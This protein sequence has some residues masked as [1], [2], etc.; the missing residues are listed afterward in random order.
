MKLYKLIVNEQQLE[1]I[2]DA[3]E[4]YSRLGIGQLENVLHNLGFKTYDQFCNKIHELHGPEVE[5]AISVIKYKLFEMSL[6][7]SH[8][9]ASSQVHENFKICYDIFT[10]I[11]KVIVKDINGKI[12]IQSEDKHKISNNG[13]IQIELCN[14]EEEQKYAS[15]KKEQKEE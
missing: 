1:V 4:S 2:K 13:L 11:Q 12:V 5:Q 3:L 14:A 15:G 9:I 7:S 10:A 8:S 6:H